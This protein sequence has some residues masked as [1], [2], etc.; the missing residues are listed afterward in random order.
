MALYIHTYQNTWTGIRL[1]FCFMLI[2]CTEGSVV[3]CPASGSGHLSIYPD[4]STYTLPSMRY[5]FYDMSEYSAPLVYPCDGNGNFEGDLPAG[6]YRVI[7]VNPD[8]EYVS[9]SGMDRETTAWVTA[10]LAFEA[11]RISVLLAQPG[12]VYAFNLGAFIL[13]SGDELSFEPVPE[14]LLRRVRIR[15]ELSES[16]RGHVVGIDGVLCGVYPSVRLFGFE[17]VI[18]DLSDIAGSQVRFRAT[19]EDA[20]WVAY[21]DVFGLCD[22]DYGRVYEN[23]LDLVLTLNDGRQANV[24]ADLTGQLSDIIKQSGG[25]IPLTLSLELTIEADE[26]DFSVSILPWDPDGG[27]DIDL[28]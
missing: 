28:R 17:P 9:F 20:R 10:D 13:S 11:S 8:A 19:A 24:Q 16:L 26:A 2:S 27:D 7:A 22:P 4:Q 21:L 18:A 15:M 14:L 23:L 25:T 12:K 6:I 5:Y 3:Y 1:L